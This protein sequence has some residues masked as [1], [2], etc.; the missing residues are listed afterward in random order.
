V[1]WSDGRWSAEHRFVSYPVAAEVAAFR[2]ARPPHWQEAV[3]E[4]EATGVYYPQRV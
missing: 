3:D 1:T 4:L 2:A